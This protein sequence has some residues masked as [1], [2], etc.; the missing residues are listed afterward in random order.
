MSGLLFGLLAAAAV[1]APAFVQRGP[2]EPQPP[3]SVQVPAVPIPGGT[4]PAI[5]PSG[6]R[7]V[8]DYAAGAR[9]D[10]TRA[11]TARADGA[12]NDAARSDSARVVVRHAIV[13][14]LPDP[15][16]SHLD[17]AFDSQVESV[18]RALETSGY[19]L[20]R[21]WLP[22]RPAAEG[23]ASASDTIR[24]VAPG[25]MLFRRAG[26]RDS[27]AVVYLVGEIPTSGI[28]AVAFAAAL[29]DRAALLTSYAAVRDTTPGGYALLRVV[30]PTFSGSAPS[31]RNALRAA[32]RAG[33]IGPADI[34]SG[35]ATAPGN[36]VLLADSTAESDTSG[37]RTRL[38]FRA[39]VNPVDRLQHHIEAAITEKLGIAPR[40]IAYLT[41]SG[42]A[43]G[44]SLQARSDTGPASKPP[45]GTMAA[46]QLDSAL[47]VALRV[48]FP[49]N[50]SRLRREYARNVLPGDTGARAQASATR[51]DWRDPASASESP[52]PLS[53]LTAPMIERTLSDIEGT[54]VLH[55]IRAVGILAT[56]VRDR[57]FLASIVKERLRDVKVFFISSH[58]LYL[59]PE[60]NSK[61]RGALVVST[62]PLFLENQYWDLTHQRR[63][64]LVFTSD[65]SEGTY[66]AVLAQLRVPDGMTD[67]AFPLDPSATTVPPVWITT[68]GANS[69][70]PV[71][72]RRG[73][74]SATSER[75]VLRRDGVP[76]RPNA[77]A[78][79]ALH[80]S[81]VLALLLWTALL[82]A[83]YRNFR[84]LR[85]PSP[86]PEDTASD[87]WSRS[88]RDALG[89]HRE[90]WVVFRFVAI[91]CAFAPVTLVVLRPQAH[92]TI[93][94]RLALGA[95]V[96]AMFVSCIG[97]AL[98]YLFLR[99]KAAAAASD[100]S[101]PRA[102]LRKQA[103]AAG[104][105]VRDHLRAHRSRQWIQ[106]ALVHVVAVLYLL[107]TAV[108][109]LQVGRLQPPDANIFFFRALSL[110][111]GVTPVVPLFAGAL[112][113]AAWS[114]W[115]IKR[116]AL[117]D[118]LSAFEAA[119]RGQRLDA[120]HVV[121][122]SSLG[123]AARFMDS[124]ARVRGGL[125]R[126]LPGRSAYALLFGLVLFGFWTI[127]ELDRSI[128]T[129]MLGNLLTVGT[130][131][132][133]LLP[134]SFD[135]LFR[136][137]MLSAIALSA[138]TL[139]RLVIVG[140][141]F[142]HLL[143]NVEAMPVGQAFSR[144]PRSIASITRFTPF[145]APPAAVVDLVIDRS[146]QTCWRRLVAM[147]V[148]GYATEACR[149]VVAASK[150]SLRLRSAGGMLDTSV[151][152]PL[153][154]LHETLCAGAALNLVP[155]DVEMP[156]ADGGKQRDAAPARSWAELAQEIVA[157]Y[158]V[159]YVEW[160][161]RHLRDLAL[162]LI[163][164]LALTTVLLA[165][166][167]FE[168]ESLVKIFFFTLMAATVMAIA[169]LLFQMSRDATMSRITHTTPGQ[170]TW[171]V[172]LVLNL[173]LVAAVPLLT[174]L[175]AQFPQI[176]D[177][178][179]SWVTPVLKAIGK[180]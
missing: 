20:D 174:L 142:R 9:A 145:S 58:S 73:G 173:M 61:M 125:I 42:T 78:A 94:T 72:A 8:A 117:L 77:E 17:W 21:F 38:R 56:D 43:Y 99:S 93:V 19:V 163:A 2:T 168:P 180:G 106:H 137:L 6:T 60:M 81:I 11:A 161:V 109:M 148:P 70:L 53:E 75:Y 66:N 140:N 130:P 114:T 135:L 172:Q 85:A 25:V 152:G 95:F 107:I 37:N 59:R 164:S 111:S 32:Q 15:V 157:L 115:H 132:V 139:Y 170:I 57:L 116:V 143:R 24:R 67:Y 76:T 86:A 103:M 136:F 122:D 102:P 88:E 179:F 131:G 41:E 51:I 79:P 101:A 113:L 178:L 10:D 112:L 48:P 23:G 121:V 169:M 28:H 177:I 162:S 134:G 30:G 33:A 153:V 55:H 105:L 92:G 46:P 90:S 167:P 80:E 5:R 4:V 151:A 62:Y 160:V 110:D 84:D 128:E 34:V 104:V 126:V 1:G 144:L 7:M 100:P 123:C 150:L 120:S 65:M 18:R 159:D 68:V 96:G 138:W 158:V 22:W 26:V 97:V 35:G 82:L 50:I 119:C 27:L 40:E 16:D 71:V 63:E 91:F 175:S 13:V 176:R 29:H 149:T 87:A 127:A 118:D 31:L 12:R 171:D 165:S 74:D 108:F 154:A 36:A 54:L 69:L 44:I 133:V 166:Y 98:H 39:T 83:M 124:V 141:A 89:W 155:L 129:I 14:I 156:E 147:E 47:H 64:R 3:A 49:M 52:A 45:T 146:A